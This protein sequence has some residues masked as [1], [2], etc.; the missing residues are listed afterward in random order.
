MSKNKSMG[1]VVLL[2]LSMLTL[3]NVGTMWS[4]TSR[5][6]PDQEDSRDAEVRR[7][8]RASF[9]VTEY[10]APEPDDPQKRAKRN[11]RGR[12]HDRSMMGVRGGLKAPRDAGDEIVL[13]TDWETRVPD[14]PAAQSEVILV[15]EVL[16]ANAFVS[17]DKNGVY[18]EFGVR[19]R[20]VLKNRSASAVRPGDTLTVER[21]GGQVR[22]P[23]GR[24][25]WH[26]IH[27]QSMPAVGRT[28][29]LFLERPEEDSFPIIT[30]YELSG[31]RV[32]PLDGGVSQFRV[33]E[34]ADEAAFLKLVRA[35][36]AN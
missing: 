6:K 17:A 36:A 9:P 12:K 5:R 26:H 8:L 11:A 23:S 30:G 34:G 13:I 18:S 19:V 15:G 1:R 21:R 27:L 35:A 14:V 25:Q 10:E 2:V 24:V 20:E 33:H 16:D 29:L 22:Y 28:Y 3:L 31:G 4:N 32:Y 7:A